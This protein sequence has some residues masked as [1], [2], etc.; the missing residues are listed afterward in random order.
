MNKRNIL[1]LLL[2]I[3]LV[4]LS[5][6]VFT[7]PALFTSF[8]FTNTGPIGD[9]IGGI[10]A[11]IINIIGAVLVYVSFQAQLEANKIQT[12]ALSNEKLRNKNNEI[13]QKHLAQFDEIKNTL[14]NLEFIVD[15]WTNNLPEINTKEPIMVFK[16]LNA[17][18][19]YTNRIVSIKKKEN[20]YSREKYQTF[21]TFLNY[22]FMLFSLYELILSI[23]LK[24]DNQSDKEFLLNN[25][26]TFYN[27]FLKVFGDRIIF[28]FGEE[29]QKEVEEIIK[30]RDFINKKFEV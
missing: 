14:R 2:G 1:I 17:L 23:E 10:T 3:G 26:K 16:G 22:Q 11:P 18:N 21:S 24:I 13:Y 7:R 4:F 25:I 30:L 8:D 12:K 9:T 28:S 5:L 20:T 6:Y 29:N 19:E 27:I 15:F